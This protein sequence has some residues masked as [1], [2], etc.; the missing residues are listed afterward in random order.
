MAACIFNVQTKGK[1]PGGASS[2]YFFAGRV[3][4]QCVSR[5]VTGSSVQ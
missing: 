2:R 5:R 4:Q 3:S 1:S